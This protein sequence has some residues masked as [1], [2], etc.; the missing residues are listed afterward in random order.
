MFREMNSVLQVRNQIK[1]DVRQLHSDVIKQ[2]NQQH[3]VIQ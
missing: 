1:S 3:K 2:K